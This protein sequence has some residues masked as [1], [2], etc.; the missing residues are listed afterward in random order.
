VWN[1]PA[2]CVVRV[3][4]YVVTGLAQTLGMVKVLELAGKKVKVCKRILL[5]I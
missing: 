2:D 3:L 4:Q 5:N 1:R